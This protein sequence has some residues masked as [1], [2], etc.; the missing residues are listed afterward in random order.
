MGHRA[1]YLVR[2]N[3]CSY[4]QIFLNRLSSMGIRDRPIAPRSPWQN[5]YVERLIA[6][7]RRECLDHVLIFGE[8]HLR[9]VLKSYS[10]YY[11][12]TRT[13]LG[14]DKDSPLPRAV[15]RMVT[16]CP[17]Q[18][19]PDCTI[20]MFGYDFREGQVRRQTQ[21]TLDLAVIDPTHSRL[22][23]RLNMSNHFTGLSLGPPLGNQRLDLCDLY[24]FQSPTDPLRTVIILNA[25]PNADALH[26]DAIYRLNIDNDGDLLTD[27]ALSYVFS[28]PQNGK[29]TFDVFLAKGTELRSPEA[30]GKKIV[31]DA[32]VSFGLSA[33]PRQGG[34]LSH[35]SPAVAA[36]PSFSISTGSRICSIS[37]ANAISPSLTSPASLRGPAWIPNTEAN[38][39]SMVV[40]LPTSELAPKSR[41][42]HLGPLQC[43]AGR[44]AAPRRSRRSSQCQQLF[45]HRRHET[46]IQRQRARQRSRALA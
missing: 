14:L 13:H 46:G 34:R 4:G 5:P 27:V 20:A 23:W 44:Q 38:V 7:L 11:N 26:P 3:D 29:Q 24:V 10:R 43:A 25:N 45:Q 42:A 40:E 33:Q 21:A 30:V 28:K 16:L 17:C 12:E 15:R 1:A 22:Q 41:T 19:S 8:R 37:G 36:T 9:S 35:S 2:D 6:T 18:S 31:A 39:F 32:E